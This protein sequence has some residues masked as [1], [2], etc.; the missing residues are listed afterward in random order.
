MDTTV[1]PL[2]LVSLDRIWGPIVITSG[3]VSTPRQASQNGLSIL[4]FSHSVN[5]K[6]RYFQ[7]NLS[8]L[9]YLVKSAEKATKHKPWD[10]I[11]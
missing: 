3:A 5:L 4:M 11:F 6:S 7:D 8:S 1:C 9:A 10:V 2:G